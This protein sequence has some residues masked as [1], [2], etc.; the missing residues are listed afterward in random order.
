MVHMHTAQLL[1]ESQGIDKATQP[2]WIVNDVVREE[3]VFNLISM[4]LF[5]MF[6]NITLETLSERAL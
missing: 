4:Y 1:R 3:H 6:C 5:G 2:L